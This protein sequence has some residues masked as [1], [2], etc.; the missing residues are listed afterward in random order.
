MLRAMRSSRDFRRGRIVIRNCDRP[1]DVNNSEIPLDFIKGF[2]PK[3][4]NS[5][6]Y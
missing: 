5:A 4:G 1:L 2:R 3:Y 6:R